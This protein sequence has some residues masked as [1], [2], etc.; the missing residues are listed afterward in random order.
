[1]MQHAPARLCGLVGAELCSAFG[2]AAPIRCTAAAAAGATVGAAAPR[3]DNAEAATTTRAASAAAPPR[4]KQR[5]PRLLL[6]NG[7]SSGSGRWLWRQ[8][9]PCCHHLLQCR[10]GV[11]TESVG[12]AEARRADSFYNTT[13]EAF[14]QQPI[15]PLSLRALLDS[16]RRAALDAD[17]VL[18]NAREVGGA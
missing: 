5:A 13:V 8:Q 14:A 9:Q 7:S 12:S 4:R 3:G 10:R 17:Y 15:A 11:Y 1:M 2:A 18:R 6:P 16:G